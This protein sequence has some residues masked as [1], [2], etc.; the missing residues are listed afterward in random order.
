ML[1][2]HK[3]SFEIKAEGSIPCPPGSG[4]HEGLHKNPK[5]LSEPARENKALYVFI[6]G[7]SSLQRKKQKYCNPQ[8]MQ[9]GG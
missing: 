2:Q 8:Q 9:L 3:F 7:G 4:I 6:S 5:M 1:G